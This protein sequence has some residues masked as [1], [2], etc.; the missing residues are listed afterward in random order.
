MTDTVRHSLQ[1]AAKRL[2]TVSS[3]PRLDAE[4]L[5]AHSLEWPRSRLYSQAQR[6]LSPEAR[7]QFLELLA[8]RASG[9]PVAYL[10]G[11][12]EFWSLDFELGDD[13]LVPRPETESL[14]E[15]ALAEPDGPRRVL[16]LGTG[17]GVIAIAIKR[18]R[19]DWEV[20]A[21][22]CS[23]G[24]LRWARH[25]AARHDA[26]VTFLEGR[27]FE[28]VSGRRFDLILANPPY[29]AHG[30]PHL[31]ALRHEPT[32][33]LVAGADGLADIRHICEQAS[34][35]LS[36]GGMLALE[37]GMDQAA[38]VRELLQAAGLRDI[39][40]ERDLAGHERISHGRRP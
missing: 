40:S 38:A 25:N 9:R 12:Q 36:P 35:Y 21:V 29:I 23:P 19:P 20:S 3:S 26:D 24:A 11:R 17:S 18:E 34:A 22:D 31:E 30:D 8:A 13:C 15:L 10:L 5:L 32:Q 28:P 7:A 4:L 6:A 2:A 39:A 27:W 33:A 37:H 16:D 1:D 14:V